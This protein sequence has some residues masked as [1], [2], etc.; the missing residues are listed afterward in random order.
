MQFKGKIDFGD[1]HANSAFYLNN[2]AANL[3]FTPN[4]GNQKVNVNQFKNTG[5]KQEENRLKSAG[6][7][8]GL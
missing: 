1:I 6:G 2:R 4:F 7:G 5:I 3:A 8:T